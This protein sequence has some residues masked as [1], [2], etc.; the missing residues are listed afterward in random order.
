M[1]QTIQI[2]N[3]SFC[4]ELWLIITIWH[5]FSAESSCCH[6]M[7]FF[8]N[9]IRN[10]SCSA[11]I[12]LSGSLWRIWTQEMWNI[13]AHIQSFIFFIKTKKVIFVKVTMTIIS[14]NTS[15]KCLQC[16]KYDNSYRK[17]LM[18][19]NV[20]LYLFSPKIS[21]FVKVIHKSSH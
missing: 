12:L 7:E 6:K 5:I 11:P 2:F 19:K 1:Q 21:P 3:F 9:S 20:V 17:S 15:T 14:E 10:A 13:A 16:I 18:W 8:R 4:A